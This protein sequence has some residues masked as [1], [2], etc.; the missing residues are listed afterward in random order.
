M[1]ARGLIIAAPSSGAGKTTLTLAIL[2]ALARRGVRVRAAKAGP[3]YIDP[4]FHAAATGHPALNLDSWAMGPGLLDGLLAEA[5]NGADL[6]VIET[7]MGLFDGAGGN[8]GGAGLGAGA[9]LAAR[10]GLPVILVQDVTGQAQSAAAVAAGFAHFAAGVTLA[11]V[12]L[13]RVASARHRDLILPALAACGIAA[14]GAFP[15]DGG[16]SLP[17]RHLGLVQAGEHP[18]LERHLAALAEAAEADL[19][20]DV[21]LAAARP[22]PGA[23]RPARA[24]LP[25]PGQ[26]IA[27]ARDAAFSFVYPHLLAAWRAQGAEIL[28]FSP[29]ADE[30]PPASADACWLPGG[31]P[32]LHAGTL[33]AAAR[34][35]AGIVR[36]AADH[37]V[38]GECGG[39]MVLGTYLEDR[40][41]GRHPMLGLLGHG[42]SFAHRRLTL[43]YRRAALAAPGPLG[44]AGQWLRGHEFHYA[45]VIDPGGDPPLAA[46]FDAR[47]QKLGPAGGR[48]GRVSGG[49]FH[50]IA[51]EEAP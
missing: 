2:A 49:F 17:A 22:L 25:P 13:N 12:I 23:S 33:A 20:L 45:S 29:L 38:H 37:P 8:P 35:R 40:D 39:Y 9:E 42:T 43:G 26:R 24:A 18:D 1:T 27:L 14:F 30:A 34:F 47:G 50:V 11:G 32:E 4:G 44:A 28:P 46:L 41:G 5:G 3:D 31:Y 51:Q 19:D 48:R 6:L 36:L 15:R 7:A 21:I 10:F 16:F